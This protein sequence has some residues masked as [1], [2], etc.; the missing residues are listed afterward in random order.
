[1]GFAVLNRGFTVPL[2]CD[3]LLESFGW[4]WLI[5]HDLGWLCLVLSG[6]GCI[7]LVY[8]DC[9]WFC[10]FWLFWGGLDGCDWFVIGFGWL[11]LVLAGFG[12]LCLVVV[13][14]RW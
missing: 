12:W 5:T 8:G 4:V 11:W 10:W 7:W 9:G 3:K 13:G 2:N 14:F 6:L 1:M